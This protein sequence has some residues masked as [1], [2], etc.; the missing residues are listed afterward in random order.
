MHDW[1][2]PTQVM[3]PFRGTKKTLVQRTN[4]GIEN[5]LQGIRDKG[6]RTEDKIIDHNEHRIEDED[7]V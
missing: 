6:E 4:Q 3:V 2:H 5:R 7:Q 1:L